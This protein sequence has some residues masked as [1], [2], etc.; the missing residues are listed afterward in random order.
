MEVEEIQ[1]RL[2]SKYG[3]TE[4]HIDTW[5]E[6]VKDVLE[7][8]MDK[9]EIRDADV[10]ES[11]ATAQAFGIKPEESFLAI[12]YVAMV[13]Q[14][15]AFYPNEIRL[16][17]PYYKMKNDQEMF[18]ETL[19]QAITLGSKQMANLRVF[20][21]EW[22]EKPVDIIMEPKKVEDLINIIRINKKWSSLTK[23]MPGTIQPQFQNY[24]SFKTSDEKSR[25]VSLTAEQ[26]CAIISPYMYTRSYNIVTHIAT[27]EGC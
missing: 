9:T 17:N 15:F 18:V 26:A 10:H 24:G 23:T 20:R 16:Q 11:M 5:N 19:G 21:G 22:F 13:H 3:L 6:L 27:F 14:K 2:E 12:A 7:D 25:V 4:E 8:I 1:H